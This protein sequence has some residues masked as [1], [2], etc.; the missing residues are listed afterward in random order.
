MKNKQIIQ[1]MFFACL[2]LLVAPSMGDADLDKAQ[3]IPAP[4]TENTSPT[5][6]TAEPATQPEVSATPSSETPLEATETPSEQPAEETPPAEPEVPAAPQRSS[7]SLPEIGLVNLTP[8]TDKDPTTG[9]EFSGM[10]APLPEAGKQLNWGPL[11]ITQGQLRLIENKLSYLGRATVFGSPATITMKK[12]TEEQDEPALAQEGG[13]LPTS[14]TPEPLASTE[15]LPPT[16][17]TPAKHSATKSVAKV[18]KEKV[19]NKLDIA[20]KVRMFPNVI[21][22]IKFDKDPT[23]ELIP[24][25]KAVLTNV[26]L[27]LE[28]GQPIKLIGTTNILGQEVT[29]TFAIDKDTGNTDAWGEF[30]NTPF[31]SLISKLKNT[32]AEKILLTKC[33]LTVKNLINKTTKASYSIEGIADISRLTGG[34]KAPLLPDAN[35]TAPQNTPDTTG[36]T[37]TPSD[38]TQTP[39]QDV[40]TIKG[41]YTPEKFLFTIK[42]KAFSIPYVGNV[43]D[44]KIL[45]S[46]TNDLVKVKLAG[47]AQVKLPQIGETDTTIDA[48]FTN[49]GITFD[50]KF[51]KKPTIEFISGKK[52]DISHANIT[53][54][55]GEP[56]KI[57]ATTTIL[58][59]EVTLTFSVHEEGT[60]ASAEFQNLPFDSIIPQ[61]KGT[62]AEQIILTR[63][64]ITIK[65][66]VSKTQKASYFLDGLADISKLTGIATASQQVA[67]EIPTQPSNNSN[68]T[69]ESFAVPSDTANDSSIVSQIDTQ[70]D[71]QPNMQDPAQTLPDVPVIPEGAAMD[72]Q[73]T[74]TTHEVSIR[75]SFIPKEKSLFVVKSKVFTIPDVGIVNDAKIVI[76]ST[77]DKVKLRLAGRAHITLPGVGETDTALDAT[78]TN[79]GINFDV[80]FDR[81]PTIEFIPGKKSDISRAT[82]IIERGQPTRIITTTTILG[83]EVTITFIKGKG[84]SEVSA[85][86]NDLPFDSVIPEFKGTP[87]ENILLKKSK[88]TI[89][90]FAQKKQKPTYTIEGTADIS[91]LTGIQA[92]TQP[93]PGQLPAE[94]AS[95]ETIAQGPPSTSPAIS[96]QTSS[97]QAA[98]TGTTST[99]A[100]GIPQAATTDSQITPTTQEVTIKGSYTP[101]QKS[102]FSI[103]TQSVFLPYAGRIT[104]AAIVIS[105]TKETKKFKLGGNLHMD[106]P[107]IGI[108]DAVID[109]TLTKTGI[110]FSSKVDKKISFADIDITNV[111]LNFS[112]SQKTIS[113]SGNGM[114]QGYPAKIVLSKGP[115]G[116][117]SAEA[118]LLDREFKP[119]SKTGV[120]TLT[121][122]SFKNPRFIFTK[123]TKGY[124]VLMSGIVTIFNIDLQGILEI[125]K[126]RGKTITLIKADAPNIQSIGA[127]VKELK[128]TLLDD[129]ELEQLTFIISND[130]V[131]DD[132]KQV[133]YK[134]GINF[135]ANTKLSGKLAPVGTFTGTSSSTFISLIGYLAS[136]PIESIFKAAIPTS[137]PIKSDSVKLGKLEL[138]ITGQPAAFSLLTTLMVKPSPQ[139]DTLTLTSRISFKLEP[140]A[141]GLAGTMQGFWSHPFGIRGLEV[142][143]VAA[144]I[145]FGPAFP[146]T[147]IP[148]SFGIAGQMALGSRNV[149]VA[150]KVPLAGDI[151]SVLCGALDKLTL[152]DI[153]NIAVSSATAVSGK[154]LTTDLFPDDIRIENMKLYV[155]PKATT[156]GEISFDEG[157][158]VRGSIV[159]PVFKA[160]GNI[161]VSSSGLIAQASCTEIKFGPKEAPLLLVS[162]SK[163]DTTYQDLKTEVCKVAITQTK[164]T[165]DLQTLVDALDTPNA[166]RS[167][168]AVCAP[169]SKLLED[170][171]GPTM[172]MVLNMEQDLSKQGILVSGLFKVAGIFEQDSYFRMDKSGIEF[173]LETA[174]GKE[175]YHGKPLLQTCM[176]GKSSGPLTNPDFKLILDFQQ[177]FLL[178]VREQ[179]IEAIAKAKEKVKQDIASA[180]KE[181]EE[182]LKQANKEAQAG[183]DNAKAQVQKAQDALDAINK[184]IENIKSEFRKK[185]DDAKKQR[186]SL[187]KDVDDLK[188]KI[189][190]KQKECK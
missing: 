50:L 160:F 79:K 122:I 139:D 153:V 67:M 190:E 29:I 125:K 130:E 113:L 27:T 165:K 163:K 41:S 150:L 64:K 14:T 179:S 78:F 36:A 77:P 127:V 171:N 92:P 185:R 68:P 135:V 102:L 117:I 39:L 60:D 17:E 6:S 35:Q 176:N 144:Q 3:E 23:I 148:A 175:A 136:N 70:G 53:T 152:N 141:I 154:K 87:G 138:E 164:S 134:K 80:I 81:R 75:G 118:E 10:Q 66:F 161:T 151:D 94:T 169:D 170:Y 26:E 137:V 82:I 123:K 131:V 99:D 28:E 65:N 172:R 44:A 12:T 4:E 96:T 90:N 52:S 55:E 33:T 84:R 168:D 46:S 31:D 73:I 103:K 62:P 9:T 1:S 166:Q 105:S 83:Q 16:Q 133:T 124:E 95:N 11:T 89:K 8:F 189:D 93:E 63:V 188:R 51:D 106:F 119:F 157:F 38:N 21:L 47:H 184:Q 97:M 2:L 104:N 155:V 30:K 181:S 58:G 85:E 7:V 69:Q 120:P 110:D 116:R 173:N 45:I 76:S 178:Y 149:A 115:Q 143:N 15:T 49:K 71:V 142:G 37:P 121:D 167:T 91:K 56:T 109:A 129:V 114:V 13:A 147:G 186:E 74:P 100:S 25:K 180:K 57:S 72:S 140:L 88:I 112:S 146:E 182:K 54:A 59:Q 101:G 177:Y 32:P 34:Q 108:L 128:G 22:S 132:E 159:L 61:F 20:G 156:I 86:F 145:D 183:I 107:E 40:V 187:Q 98:S 24:G 19:L 5:E 111:S 42:S 162:R 48:T 18:T 174:L 158:T 43:S 126:V